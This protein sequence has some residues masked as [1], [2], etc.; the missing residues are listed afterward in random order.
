VLLG[1]DIKLFLRF[2]DDLTEDARVAL[3]DLAV[4]QLVFGQDTG[5]RE[6]SITDV[7]LLIAIVK[8]DLHV[9]LHFMAVFECLAAIHAGYGESLRGY[10]D[11][12]GLG[13]RKGGLHV[14]HG[15]LVFVC[16]WV[17]SLVFLFILVVVQW[18]MGLVI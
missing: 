15:Y 16:W 7:A 1:V 12:Q 8:V 18:V 4:G 14:R 9:F 6:H 5:G 10:E 2:Q 11:W 13:G 3:P 17:W